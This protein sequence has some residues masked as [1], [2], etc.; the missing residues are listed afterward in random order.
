MEMAGALAED[1]KALERGIRMYDAH[2]GTDVLVIAPVICAL[3]D[4]VRAAELVNHLGSRAK[5]FCWKC[6]VY[7]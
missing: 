4:N 5:M 3:R 7:P 1:L 2:T 6:M